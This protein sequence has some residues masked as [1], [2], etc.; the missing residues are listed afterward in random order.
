MTPDRG[1]LGPEDGERARA[2]C[3]KQAWDGIEE[4][5]P[6]PQHRGK[7]GQKKEES[8]QNGRFAER[9]A[10][11]QQ[12]VN[13]GQRQRHAQQ[14]SRAGRKGGGVRG[15]Q[16]RGGGHGFLQL[17]APDGSKAQVIERHEQDKPG[18]GEQGPAHEQNVL[19]RFGGHGF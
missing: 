18:Y 19:M 17:P 9:A 2:P 5:A 8:G 12:I 15:K 13:E 14:E 7:A 6:Q 4:K 1:R 10:D 3:G 16:K 11:E